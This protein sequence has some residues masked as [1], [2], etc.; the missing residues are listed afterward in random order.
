MNSSNVELAN[1]NLQKRFPLKTIYSQKLLEANKDQEDS[2]A[3]IF[4]PRSLRI[5]NSIIL[6]NFSDFASNIMSNL[7]DPKSYGLVGKLYVPIK[8]FSEPSFGNAYPIIPLFLLSNEI[9]NHL[10]F[11]MKNK[12]ND[13]LG[14]S[15]DYYFNVLDD[16]LSVLGRTYHLFNTN[17][18]NK[19][20]FDIIGANVLDLA[21]CFFILYTQIL[22][23]DPARIESDFPCRNSIS[24]EPERVKLKN[25]T[26]RLFLDYKSNF[27][28]DLTLYLKESYYCINDRYLRGK[29][30]IKFENLLYCVRPDLFISTMCDFPYFLVF[31][32]LQEDEKSEFYNEFGKIALE[33]Y[34]RSIAQRALGDDACK[35]YIYKKRK[36]DEK[37]CGEFVIEIDQD[38]LVIVEIKGAK[39]DDLIRTGD[40]QKVDD[41]F[42]TIPNKKNKPKGIL[43]LL[44]SAKYYRLGTSFSGDIYTILIFYGRFPETKEFDELVENKIHA[45]PG[46][47]AYKSNPKNH[48]TIWLN[49]FAAELIFSA[50][51]QGGDLKEMLI[52]ISKSSPSS[53]TSDVWSYMLDKGLKTSLAALFKPELKD[54][55]DRVKKILKPETY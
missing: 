37:P 38:T 6:V 2:R 45:S 27:V 25:L 26:D 3:I 48:P 17:Y 36:G 22:T 34:I 23:H 19:K 30:Y 5:L 35:E 16:P 28:Q 39:E 32:S 54:I 31:N 46:Y 4:D 10:E 40:S 52:A 7:S 29:P 44:N 41:K 1:E 8:E 15:I 21:S 33:N 24:D 9:V 51:K 43:Q 12:N 18:F 49:C 50:V 20:T 13:I 42:I 14:T 55:S 11:E 47:H 53:V